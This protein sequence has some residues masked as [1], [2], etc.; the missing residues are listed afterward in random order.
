VIERIPSG[1]ETILA[2]SV[3]SSV[4]DVELDG[5]GPT[6]A[7]SC[8]PSGEGAP[9]AWDGRSVCT[10]WLPTPSGQ[11]VLRT[12]DGSGGGPASPDVAG[13]TPSRRGHLP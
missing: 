9:A 6:G 8:A 12:Y 5:A 7:P 2:L 11:G 3:P 4:T 13:G 10:L 1:D